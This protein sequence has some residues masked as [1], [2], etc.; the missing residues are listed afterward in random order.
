MYNIIIKKIYITHLCIHNTY[1]TMLN[2]MILSNCSH[3]GV[4]PE[5]TF[6][7]TIGDEVVEY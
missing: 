4:T 2:M 6:T 1:M 3:S 5:Q 7:H